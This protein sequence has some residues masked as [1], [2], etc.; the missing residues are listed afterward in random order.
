MNV[1][2]GVKNSLLS[3]LKGSER[4]I[5]RRVLY[6]QFNSYSDQVVEGQK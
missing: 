6:E 3:D 5:E 4:K 1:S 2:G